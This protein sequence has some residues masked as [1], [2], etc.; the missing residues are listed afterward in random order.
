MTKKYF[1]IIGLLFFT[2]NISAQENWYKLHLTDSVTVSFPKRPGKGDG[3][4]YGCQDSSGV[5]FAASVSDIAKAINFDKSTFDSVVVEKDFANDF[6]D[7]FKTSLPNYKFK[8]VI[9]ST[10]TGKVSYQ[11]EGRNEESKRTVYFTA[12]FNR[13]KAYNLIC[14]LPDGK[15]VRDKNLFFKGINFR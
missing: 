7:G 8:P 4:S 5:L 9:I 12:I 11:F 3:I 10:L 1:S 6:L 13:G 2:L 15:S 14:I